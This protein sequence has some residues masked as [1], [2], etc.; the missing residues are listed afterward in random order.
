MLH[1]AFL[2][3]YHSDCANAATHCAPV[4]YSPLTMRLAETLGT[5]LVQAHLTAP[6]NSV[7]QE[8]FTVLLALRAEEQN[9]G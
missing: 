5:E 6:S 8:V 9:S 7:Y 1:T 4:R 3:A 2:R